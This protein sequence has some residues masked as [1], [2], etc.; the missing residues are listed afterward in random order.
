M[1]VGFA[2]AL[3]AKTLPGSI[4]GGTHRAASF[5]AAESFQI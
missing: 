4:G 5:A 2:G 3:V 1:V